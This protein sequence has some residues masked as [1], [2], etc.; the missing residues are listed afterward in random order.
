MDGPRGTASINDMDQT[1]DT[2]NSPDI[3]SSTD[4]QNREYWLDRPGSTGLLYRILLILCGVLLMADVLN[5]LHILYHKHGH[6]A[7][8]GWFGFYAIF[9]F[10]AYALIVGAGW[11]WRRVVMRGEDYYTDADA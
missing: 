10:V 8:E 11:I 9:G 1:T 5:L 4:T 3:E 7:A 2:E 6:Y